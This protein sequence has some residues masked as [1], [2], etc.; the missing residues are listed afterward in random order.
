MSPLAKRWSIFLA[1]AAVLAA[2]SAL[3][4]DGLR[5]HRRLEADAGR[6]EAENEALRQENARLRREARALAGD[7]AALERAAREEL[8][9]VRPGEMIYKIG[10]GEGG[11]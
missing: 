11:R 8:G 3:D 9:F 10:G 6:V 1:A 7:P 2:L 4:R 5:K